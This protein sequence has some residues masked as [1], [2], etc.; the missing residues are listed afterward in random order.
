MT[1]ISGIDKSICKEKKYLG[2]IKGV[3]QDKSIWVR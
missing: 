3:G 1:K 2:M